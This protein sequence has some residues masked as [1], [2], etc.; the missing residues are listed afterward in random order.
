MK[1]RRI[2]ANAHIMIAKHPECGP[3]GLDIDQV[4]AHWRTGLVDGE[5]R[6]PL[7]TLFVEEKS[8]VKMLEYLKGCAE[9]RANT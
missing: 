1:T 5:I 9:G 7:H 3:L 6:E 2:L 8:F 4:V